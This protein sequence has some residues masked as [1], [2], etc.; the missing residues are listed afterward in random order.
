MKSACDS[1]VGDPATADPVCAAN[2]AAQA[3]ALASGSPGAERIVQS[4]RQCC[5][6]LAQSQWPRVAWRFSG[7][8]ADGSPLEFAF[9]N[10]DN[11]MRFTI[12]VA[13]PECPNHARFAAACDL[14]LSLGHEIPADRSL[15]IQMQK[16]ATLYWGARLGV[17][18]SG[19]V[20]KIKY[21][22]EV[23]LEAQT[24]FRTIPGAPLKD[25][26]VVM[27][28][29]DPQSGATEYYFRQQRLSE[30]KL[31]HL[32][33]EFGNDRADGEIRDA[34]EQLSGMPIASALEWT[35]FGFSVVRQKQTAASRLSLFARCQA[36]GG[37]NRARQRMIA[38]M[39]DW[40]K[41]QSLYYRLVAYLP[42]HELPD[43]GVISITPLPSSAPEMRVGLSSAALSRLL[44]RTFTDE[45][46]WPC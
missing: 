9:S 16:N 30:Y 33:S 5:E 7:L 2:A 17:R 38:Q 28:G 19:G 27:I 10:A 25:S 15:W 1:A 44:Q 29:F 39:P 35:S 14:A 43:H 11:L 12:D 18:E 42:K 31:D 20:E 37:A 4:L 24:L 40:V 13:P 8:T 21:Y 22:L 32:L 23:P 3:I 46:S 36:I 41:R 34:V 45:R 6:R 26:V